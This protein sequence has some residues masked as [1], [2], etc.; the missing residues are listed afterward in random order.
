MT[1]FFL[2]LFSGCFLL[3]CF[4]QNNRYTD[5]LLVFKEF[6]NAE[7][8][9]QEAEKLFLQAKDNEHLLAKA[10]EKYTGALLSFRK[11]ITDAEKTGNDSLLFFSRCR[12]GLIAYYLNDPETAKNEYISAIGIKQRLPAVADSLLFIPYLYTGSIYYS[13]T[14]IDSSLLYYKKA[15]AINDQFKVPLNG[16]ER[17]YNRLGVIYYENGNYRKA[18]NYFEK[19]ITLTSQAD[20][21]LLINYKM[22]IG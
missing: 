22:N 16:S 14:L 15:E 12:A 8:I 11:V 9:F 10:D 18:G 1:K 3:I 13:Q 5:P 2:L 7:K 19:A 4:S 20:T 17:L 6:R 21:G